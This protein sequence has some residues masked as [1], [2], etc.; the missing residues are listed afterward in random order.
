MISFEIAPSGWPLASRSARLRASATAATLAT[1]RS[2]GSGFAKVKRTRV[3]PEHEISNSRAGR[4]PDR[5]VSR[6][7]AVGAG[8]RGDDLLE[9]DVDEDRQ[10]NANLHDD[11]ARGHD[12]ERRARGEVAEE[13]DERQGRRADS[14]SLSRH[15]RGGAPPGVARRRIDVPNGQRGKIDDDEIGAIGAARQADPSRPAVPE[16]LLSSGNVVGQQLFEIDRF[17]SRGSA[18]AAVA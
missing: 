8:G 10:R 1:E 12:V 15:P 11:A 2:E 18:R 13:R 17:H 16:N 5:N 6:S 7:I 9:G 4:Q 3:G 14:N